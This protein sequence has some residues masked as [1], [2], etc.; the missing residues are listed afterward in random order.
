M[1][2]GWHTCVHSTLQGLALSLLMHDDAWQ[3][4]AGTQ[5]ASD[6]QTSWLRMSSPADMTGASE[7]TATV[8]GREPSGAGRTASAVDGLQ[9]ASPRSNG[10]IATERGREMCMDRSWFG[11]GV[12]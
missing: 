2:P 10:N 6:S 1:V 9:A 5:S 12:T 7:A 3:H 8:T 4:V 11:K